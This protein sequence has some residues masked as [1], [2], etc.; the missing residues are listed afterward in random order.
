M[1]SGTKLPFQT[2]GQEATSVFRFRFE[3][4]QLHRCKCEPFKNGTLL[5]IVPASETISEIV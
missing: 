4:I 3:G 5:L 1:A 2:I